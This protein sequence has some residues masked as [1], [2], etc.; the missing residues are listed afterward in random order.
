MNLKPIS[1]SQEIFMCYSL[2]LQRAI[3]DI[4]EKRIEGLREEPWTRTLKRTEDSKEDP[5]PE[6]LKQGCMT[7]NP[8][9]DPIT[10]DSKEDAITEDPREEPKKDPKEDH[11]NRKLCTGP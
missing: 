8:T 4:L 10:K 11:L 9:E 3:F 2:N 7:K 1:I 6:D 5:M